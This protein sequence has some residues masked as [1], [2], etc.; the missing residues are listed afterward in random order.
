MIENHFVAFNV[1]T[2]S[3]LTEIIKLNSNNVNQLL[4]YDVSKEICGL[5][6]SL[7]MLSRLYIPETESINEVC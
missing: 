4:D 5:V 6:F 2:N 7:I 1:V 3:N